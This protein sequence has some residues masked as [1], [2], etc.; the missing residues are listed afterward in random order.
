LHGAYFALGAEKG[1]EFITTP[2]TFIATANA[3]LY[4]GLK[5]VFSDIENDTGN[6]NASLVEEKITEKTKFIVPVHYSGHPVDME[7]ISTIAEKHNLKIIEDATHAVGAKYKDRIIG[8]CS[9]SEMAAFSF[10]PVKHITCGE[11][12]AVLTNNEEYFRKLKMFRSHGVRKFNLE[13]R[14]EGEW[15]YEMHLL[16]YNY[17]MT[18]FQAAL[19]ISQL[20][21]LESNISRRR[22]IAAEYDKA[23]RNHPFLH[24][25]PERDY[26]YSSYHLYPV[27]LKDKS[28]RK[29]FFEKLHERNIKVQVHYIPVYLQ[30]YY[31]NMGYRKGVCPVAEDF[32]ER[33]ISLPVYP[34]LNA[35]D[36][37]YVINIINTIINEC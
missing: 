24:I 29:I 37:A 36:Q 1:S 34:D 35:E 6:L 33:E 12:G 30:P 5:P 22:E 3:G 15:Y 10:H 20:S 18:D 7:A 17:R 26:A 32:Y 19:G 16:G 25:P 14:N 23:F 11:G 28:K 9:L 13:N 8:D 27:R 31:R 2:L 4:L 21:R